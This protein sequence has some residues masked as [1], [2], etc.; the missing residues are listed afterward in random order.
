MGTQSN[1]RWG[2]LTLEPPNQRFWVKGMMRRTGSAARGNS[3]FGER[4]DK[5]AD[6]EVLV[7]EVVEGE[8]GSLREEGPRSAGPVAF[9]GRTCCRHLCWSCM[10]SISRSC[11]V[12]GCGI[13]VW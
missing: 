12:S 2:R 5:V 11:L 6:N 3:S 1:R 8:A 13:G 10:G 9:H 4:V 7:G